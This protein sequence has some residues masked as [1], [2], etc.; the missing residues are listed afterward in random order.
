MVCKN[1]RETPMDRGLKK[2]HNYLIN[3]EFADGTFSL[4]L[5][6]LCEENVNVQKKNLMI[7]L[8]RI[9]SKKPMKKKTKLR[10]NM[11]TDI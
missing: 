3:Q 7:F 4:R 10:S 6:F 11:K 8:T 1:E 9:S 2:V 5:G